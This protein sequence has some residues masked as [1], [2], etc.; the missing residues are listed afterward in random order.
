[1]IQN[2]RDRLRG[3]SLVAP[4]AKLLAK[5]FHSKLRGPKLRRHV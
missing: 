5:F 4:R 3:A 2:V 1:M